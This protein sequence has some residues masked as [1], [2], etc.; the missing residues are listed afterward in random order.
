VPTVLGKLWCGHIT[1]VF[2]SGNDWTGVGCLESVRQLCCVLRRT[3]S[4]VA[5]YNL[6][7]VW[8][9]VMC[10]LVLENLI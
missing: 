5:A 6:D 3:G 7:P 8:I 10:S 1:S 2:L 9:N 4:P